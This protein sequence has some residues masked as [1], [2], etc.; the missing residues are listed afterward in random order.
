MPAECS[1]AD[2]CRRPSGS[3]LHATDFGEKQTIISSA[4]L[5]GSYIDHAG[6]RQAQHSSRPTGAECRKPAILF[7]VD[8]L[9]EDGRLREALAWICLE[10]EINPDNL[11]AQS[12]K[13]E[14]ERLLGYLRSSEPEEWVVVWNEAPE[15]D[16][17]Q[18]SRVAF[19]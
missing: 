13:E 19:R 6:S 16:A 3:L 9:R 5:V 12:M 2:G 8:L 7:K 11:A 18:A 4:R 10:C 1:V 17:P 15:W 14:L